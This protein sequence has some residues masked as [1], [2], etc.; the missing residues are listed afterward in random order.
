MTDKQTRDYEKFLQRTPKKKEPPPSPPT[1]EDEEDLENKKFE[2]EVYQKISE[3]NGQ[4]NRMSLGELKNLCKTLHLDCYGKRDPLKRRLKEHY[5]VEKLVAAGLMEPKANPNADYFLIIDFE[6]TCEE[7]NPPGYPHEVIE[8][9]AILVTSG[10]YHKK[11][12]AIVDV[13]HSYVKPVINPKLSEFCK[14]LTGIDQETVDKSDIFQDVLKKFEVWMASHG[15]GQTK[16][17]ILI[18]DGPFD[19]GRFMYL[20]CKYS[21]ISYPDYGCYWANLRKL[22]VNFYKASFYS[23]NN[24]AMQLPGLQTMLARLG[25]EF[26]GQ[27]HSGLDDAKNIARIVVRLLKDRA[28]IRV[29][30]KIQKVAHGVDDSNRCNGK[31]FSVVPVNRKDSESWFKSQKKKINSQNPS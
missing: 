9:P 22:F 14:S 17:F 25:M 13:F 20:Q 11:E 29:N 31:L 1:F 18:T 15:L 27:P 6:A 28:V 12:P 2:H 4:I 26:E 7:K 16:T 19:M 21:E 30:E 3:M 23:N 24:H 8:F 5:K 10:D